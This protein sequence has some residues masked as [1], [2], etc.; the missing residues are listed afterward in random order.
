VNEVM[1]AGKAV[2]VSDKVGCAPDLVVEGKNGHVFPVGD[3]QALAEAIH[4]G[5][6]HSKSAEDISLKRIQS[7]SFKENIQGLKQA[8]DYLMIESA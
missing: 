4:W 1:N 7:W 8:L 2:V 6:Q 3:I 5:I